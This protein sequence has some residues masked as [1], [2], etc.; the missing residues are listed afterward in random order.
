MENLLAVSSK[1][2]ASENLEYYF[3]SYIS[4]KSIM[5]PKVGAG[6]AFL[7]ILDIFGT[8]F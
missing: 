7:E 4:S 8:L 1:L 6:A 5:S 3:S 2:N